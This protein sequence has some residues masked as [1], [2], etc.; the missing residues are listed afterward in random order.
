MYHVAYMVD[1]AG[2]CQ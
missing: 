1:N 2:A